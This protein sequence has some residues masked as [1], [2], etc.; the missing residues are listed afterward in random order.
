MLYDWILEYIMPLFWTTPTEKAIECFNNMFMIVQG[1]A[2][3]YF[4]V[5]LP[6]YFLRKAGRL[7][8]FFP[9]ADRK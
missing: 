7:P 1:G 9:W 3:I 4:T 5:Y 2:I 8:K 6:F